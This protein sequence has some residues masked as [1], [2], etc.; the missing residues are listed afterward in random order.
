[1]AKEK[2]YK[3][4]IVEEC[5][6]I[7]IPESEIDSIEQTVV[8]NYEFR[9]DDTNECIVLGYGSL[10]NHSNHPNIEY[11]ADYSRMVMVF[12]ALKDIEKGE[13]LVSDYFQGDHSEPLPKE[14]TDFKY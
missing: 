11:E 3:G 8:T 2:I 7:L 12:K 1:M 4:E 9:W 6:V 13:E 10:I 5:P 14:Y